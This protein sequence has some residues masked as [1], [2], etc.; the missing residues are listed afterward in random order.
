MFLLGAGYT[1]DGA[2][3]AFKA[4]YGYEPTEGWRVGNVLY[5]KV[6]VRE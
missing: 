1:V 2:I 6:E 4:R 5:V 3:G